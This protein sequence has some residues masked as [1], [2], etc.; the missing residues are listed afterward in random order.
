MGSKSCSP[1]PVFL[2]SEFIPTP[3]QL[4]SILPLRVGFWTYPKW[5]KLIIWVV[6]S[7]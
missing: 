1:G 6:L 3:I 2:K 7:S 4:Q 5:A